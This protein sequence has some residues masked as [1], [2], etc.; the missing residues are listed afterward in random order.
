MM[1]AQ[2]TGWWRTPVGMNT[3]GSDDRQFSLNVVRW[4][5]RGL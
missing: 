1:T 3:P 4:L 5:G 2:V